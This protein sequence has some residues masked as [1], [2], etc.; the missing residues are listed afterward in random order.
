MVQ[1][2]FFIN[3]HELIFLRSLHLGAV[4]NIQK[5]N[6]IQDYGLKKQS[7]HPLRMQH[8]ITENVG[9]GTSLAVQ[10]LRLS[11]SNAGYMDLFPGQQTKISHATKPTKKENVGREHFPLICR[12]HNHSILTTAE[13]STNL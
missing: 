6:F 3:L 4:Q 5:S 9:S 1:F 8:A 11:L 12:Q 2:I 10:G 7:R 13:H